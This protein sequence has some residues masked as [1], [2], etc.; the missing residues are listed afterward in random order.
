MAEAKRD[1]G[2]TVSTSNTTIDAIGPIAGRRGLIA[3]YEGLSAVLSGRGQGADVGRDTITVFLTRALSA[4]I[5]YL[6]QIVLAR[7]MGKLEYGVY[8]SVWTVVLVL[9]GIGNLG[10]LTTMMRLVPQYRARGDLD[11]ARGLVRYGRGVAISAG[12]AIAALGLLVL[13]AFPGLVS[14]AF[15]M[16]AYLA[17]VCL[18]LISLGDTQD[19]LGRGLRWMNIAL[20]PPY[21]LRPAL[22]LITMIVARGIGLPMT[23]ET[24]MGSAVAATWLAAMVQYMALRKHLPDVVGHGPSATKLREWLGMSLPLLAV[25]LSELV[26]QNADVLV[27]ARHLS[28]GEVAIYFAAAKTISLITFVHYAVGSA[29]ANR[30]A[31]LNAEG[32][33]AMLTFAVREAVRWTFWPSLA[34]AAALLIVGEPLLRLF[35]PSFTAAYPVMLILAVGFLARAAMGPS[36][37]ILNMLGQHRTCAVNSAAAAVVD[38]VLCVSL[39]P[40]MGLYGAAVATSSALLLAALL[41]A[42]VASK[43][44]GL[45]IAVWVSPVGR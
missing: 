37:L 36:E 26:L 38:V 11:L 27:L 22:V 45:D 7:W 13:H 10:L 28:S 21:V 31:T 39:V 43:R 5:L 32:D 40:V 14:H 2:G 6:S 25:S 12:S 4:G 29:V 1:P 8:V 16:P 30:F 3:L 23:A 33:K 35:G 34:V 41:N 15:V 19:G 42:F 24:A 20:L 18:P 17:L 9:G 44:L